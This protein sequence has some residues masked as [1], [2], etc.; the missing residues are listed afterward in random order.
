MGKVHVRISGGTGPEI[1]KE[2]PYNDVVRCIILLN[3]GLKQ[4]WTK[5]EGWTPIEAS[6]LLSKSRLDWQVSLSNCLYLWK[7]N[8]N[9][10]NRDGRLILAWANLGSLV[11]GTMK[12]FLSVHYET[13]KEDADAIRKKEK[14]INPDSCKLDDLR[15]FFEK[16][17]WWG[18][19]KDWDEWILHIQKCRNAI[20]AFKHREIG[21]FD[22]FFIDVHKYMIFLRNINDHLPYPDDDF[23]PECFN[24]IGEIA[25]KWIPETN[26]DKYLSQMSKL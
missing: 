2:L 3:E 24:R 17:I 21:T 25:G 15:Q 23:N 10:N 20:H 22:E 19:E 7:S 4:F 6:Q 16:K 12:L 1:K 9:K 13:Y 11:E 26:I 18:K 8:D 14:L 5:S